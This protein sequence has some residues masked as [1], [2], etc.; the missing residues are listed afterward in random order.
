M[1]DQSMIA[2]RLK[3]RVDAGYGLSHAGRAHR[4]SFADGDG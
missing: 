4:A 1:N 2:A 3:M